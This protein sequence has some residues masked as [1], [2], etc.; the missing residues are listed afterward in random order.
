MGEDARNADGYNGGIYFCFKDDNRSKI[1]FFD[2][3]FNDK[4]N[5]EKLPL[6]FSETNQLD[7]I[8]AVVDMTKGTLALYQ[9]DTVIFKEYQNDSFKTG[10]PVLE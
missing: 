3:R 10:F 5:A 1:C 6:N 2:D 8:R 9:G 4:A 7:N